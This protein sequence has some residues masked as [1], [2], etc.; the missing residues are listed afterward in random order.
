MREPPVKVLILGSPFVAVPVLGLC[1]LML[2]VCFQNPDAWP[3][4][5]AA[6]IVGTLTGKAQDTAIQYRRWQRAWNSLAEPREA[7]SPMP[8]L[9]SALIAVLVIGGFM[10]AD[11]GGTAGPAGGALALVGLMALPIALLVMIAKRWRSKARRAAP[12]VEPVKVA[13]TR[14]VFA[15]PSLE[16]AYRSL[17]EH[18]QKVMLS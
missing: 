17:P 10:L 14:P 9:V 11:Q 2:Y 8:R 18:S 3:L 7:R 5:V 4:G 15:V 16:A 12:T 6:L 13:V 1:G